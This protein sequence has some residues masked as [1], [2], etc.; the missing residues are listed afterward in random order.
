MMIFKSISP[1][2]KP[3]VSTG[4]LSLRIRVLLTGTLKR[5]SI[6]QKTWPEARFSMEP[7][8]AGKGE[9][10]GVLDNNFG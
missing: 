1:I 6:F 9:L 5:R 7:L 3:R 10:S 8:K 2:F 4:Y